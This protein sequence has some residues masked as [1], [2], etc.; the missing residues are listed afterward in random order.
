MIQKPMDNLPDKEDNKVT[1]CVCTYN[2]EKN[3]QKCINGIKKNGFNNILVVDASLD[4]TKKI[5][6]YVG[7][8]VVT[9]EKGLARQRQMAIEICDTE[10]LAFVDADDRIDK[11]CI[12][13]LLSELIFN[14][15]DAIGAQVRVYKPKTYWQKAIDATWKY[16]MF[17]SGN[18]NMVGRPA[19]YRSVAIKSVGADIAFVNIGDEDTA[20]SV[21]MEKKGYKQGIGTGKTYRECHASFKDNKKEWIKYGKGDAMIV[22]QYPEKR[23]AIIWHDLIEYPILRSIELIKNRCGRYI[24]YPICIG[25]TRFAVM[26]KELAWEKKA[27]NG[28]R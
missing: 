3:I 21:R 1:V 14:K 6:E 19:I 22:R 16:S 27:R 15:Y 26:I 20:I 18:T 2:E 23:K 7:A 24:L 28:Y 17:K 5:A 25:L 12:S 9:C 11:K 8:R 13:T 10:Y 4:N